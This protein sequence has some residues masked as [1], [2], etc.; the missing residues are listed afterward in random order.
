MSYFRQNIKAWNHF[1][2][3]HNSRCM[4]WDFLLYIYIYTHT[5]NNFC[6]I[7]IYC[8]AINTLAQLK[9]PS[10][11]P[12]GVGGWANILLRANILLILKH[13][14]FFFPRWMLNSK[15]ITVLQEVV[16]SRYLV[17]GGGTKTFLKYSVIR[18]IF[19]SNILFSMLH[20]QI[21]ITINKPIRRT[22]Y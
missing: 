18:E 16:C 8:T 15:E 10:E 20:Y 6:I 12:G 1:Q 13:V 11:G 22:N 9:I 19:C 4:A 21:F 3:K 5:P 17:E 7:I 2:I 14:F